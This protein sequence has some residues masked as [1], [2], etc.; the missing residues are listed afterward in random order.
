MRI[1][2]IHYSAPPIVGGVE[3]VIGHHAKLMANAGHE[4]RVVAGRGAI[5]D[6]RI[7]FTS[8][9]LIDSRN[10]RIL[11][12]KQQLDR[13]VVPSSFTKLVGEIRHRLEPIIQ[14]SDVVFAHNVCSLHKNLALTAA[15]H[16]ISQA[17]ESPRFVLFQHDLAATS[18]RYQGELHAGYP[19]D[20]LAKPWPSVKLVTISLARQQ[21]LAD[22]L[23]IPIEQI[24][25]IPNG[26]DLPAFLKLGPVVRSLISDF[27]L[28]ETAPIL[29]L[30]VRITRRKNI[31]LAL[32]IIHELRKSIP[33]AALIVTGPVGA[34]N[35]ENQRYFDEL[36]ALRSELSLDGHVHILAER[37]PDGLPDEA[38]PDLYRLADALILPSREEGFGIPLVEAGLAGLPIF[39]ADIPTLRALAGD[40]AAYFSPDAEPVAVAAV[41]EAQLAKNP[42]YRQ[43]VRVR[44]QFSWDAIYR[45]HLAPL[46]EGTDGT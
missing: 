46:L 1:S 37:I 12:A 28:L 25:V 41:I 8:L 34:H 35:P 32:R 21:E 38:I 4:V 39:A 43:K 44:Q 24:E 40:D 45:R 16:E 42:L 26:V 22:L 27:K 31:E 14:T 30:P 3:S 20:L 17:P 5:F 2:L 11:D 29:L 19:W 7:A 18:A 10:T 6:R 33:D 23:E 15:L 13:G 36:R 9:P